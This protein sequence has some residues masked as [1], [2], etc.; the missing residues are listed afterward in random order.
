[1]S[2]AILFSRSFQGFSAPQVQVETHLSPTTLPKFSIVGLPEAA[3]KESKD[4]V[5]SAIINSQFRFPHSRITVNL[6]PADLPKEGARFDLAIALGILIASQQIIVDDLE[7][8]EF[9]G[10]LGLSGELRRI[11]GA[12]P[13]A[14]ATHRAGKKLIISR[15]SADEAA[16]N[17]E[18]IVLPASH[19]LEVCAHL[20]KQQSLASHVFTPP[21]LH[22]HLLDLQEVKGQFHAKRA[23]EIAAAGGHSILMTGPPGTG[24]TMLAQRLPSI[25]PPLNQNEALEVA[26]IQSLSKTTLSPLKWQQRPFRMPHHTA[27]YAALVG[28][29][30][31]PTPGEVSLAHHGILF[32]DEL[33]EFSPKT[34]ETLREP[35]EN[36]AIT[37][38]RAGNTAYFPAQFQLIA[39]MNP[40]PCG[41]ANDREIACYCTPEKIKK[42]QSRI[43]GPLLDR[44]DLHLTLLRLSSKE[45]LTHTPVSHIT[46]KEIREKVEK[47]RQRQLELRKKLNS[48]LAPHEIMKIP[49]NQASETLLNKIIN[50][51]HLSPRA[52]HRLLK[53]TQTLADLEG[54]EI[55]QS[56]HLEEALS[57]RHKPAPQ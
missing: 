41:Y 40:C 39:A 47:A 33:A 35:L 7:N 52:Y 30:N 57:F 23:L 43:S 17:S 42:Y 15:E 27:S 9:A 25:L 37:I 10:E 12:L 1:M 51:L 32:L 34:L 31:P 29:N 11:Q 3:I 50:H 44:I 4:R 54:M 13:F 45:L 53:V 2:L 5:R 24:K 8:Y 18:L 22:H 55:I 38:A 46:S 49:L 48:Q 28:G 16:L 36:G 56:Y 21:P 19:L 6:A 20:S 26:A 14:L